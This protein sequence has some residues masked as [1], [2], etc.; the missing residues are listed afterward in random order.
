MRPQE[1][2]KTPGGGAT[3]WAGKSRRLRATQSPERQRDPGETK[4][5]EPS[6]RHDTDEGRMDGGGREGDENSLIAQATRGQGPNGGDGM[7]R[8]R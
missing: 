8:N 1:W 6:Q 4:P 2:R 5:Q 3:E 7:A